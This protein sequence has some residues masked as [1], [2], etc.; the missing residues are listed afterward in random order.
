LSWLEGLPAE[1]NKVT[2]NWEGWN[3]KAEN[4]A[5]SQ[6]LLELTQVFCEPGRCLDCSWGLYYLKEGR[7][8][9]PE[10]SNKVLPESMN[11]LI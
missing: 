8:Y 11:E 9:R 6:A 4:A 1:Q 7:N 10:S 2:R 5:E 3:V